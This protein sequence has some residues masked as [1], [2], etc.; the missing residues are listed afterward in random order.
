MLQFLTNEKIEELKDR[1]FSVI[2]YYYD[3]I[4]YENAKENLEFKVSKS[5]NTL[6]LILTTGEKLFKSQN[7]KH[8]SRQIE[9]LKIVCNL[10]Y[11]DEIHFK[12]NSYSFS[13]LIPD[14]LIQRMRTTFYDV[15]T[16]ILIFKEQEIKNY[17]K[18]E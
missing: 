1:G 15:P 9:H 13:S 3:S 14:Y 2:F 8:F 17:L 18:T 5:K 10:D 7:L 6:F 16:E 11:N 12:H 4:H